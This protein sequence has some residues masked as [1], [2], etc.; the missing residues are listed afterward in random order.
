MIE[1]LELKLESRYQVVPG[2]L[3]IANKSLIILHLAAIDGS[4]PYAVNSGTVHRNSAIIG[5]TQTSYQPYY[6]FELF[7]ILSV[8]LV[9]QNTKTMNGIEAAFFIELEI[10]A[11]KQILGEV[12]K[13]IIILSFP[14]GGSTGLSAT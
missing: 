10:L 11:A 5:H 13:S 9:F 3:S 6:A 8:H 2:L 12:T 7:L 1:P 4:N 14:H